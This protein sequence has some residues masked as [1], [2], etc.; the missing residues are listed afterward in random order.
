MKKRNN[1]S[2]QTRAELLRRLNRI[3]GINIP[4]NAIDKY[5]N[6][7]LSALAYENSRKRFLR[8]I[9]WTIDQVA[10]VNASSD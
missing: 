6:V 10:A 8:C 7:P 3:D 5:P 1:L 9:R 2:E 4:Q